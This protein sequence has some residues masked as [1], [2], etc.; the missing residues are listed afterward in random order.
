MTGIKGG[1]DNGNSNVILQDYENGFHE[2]MESKW[3]GSE[4]STSQKITG[5][6]L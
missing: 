6:V 2:G 1:N 5:A 4:K 3:R